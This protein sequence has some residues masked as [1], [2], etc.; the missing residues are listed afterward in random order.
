[1]L[2]Y[3][4]KQVSEELI[5]NRLNFE[6][7]WWSTGAIDPDYSGMSARLYLTLFLK[8]LEQKEVHRSIVMMGPRRV[9]KTVL[10][11]HAVSHLISKG[12]SPRKIAFINIENPI[13]LNMSLDQL[14]AYAR[15]AV[16]DSEAKGWYVFF[17]EIQY[18][19]E[20]EIHMKVL[21]D[22]YRKTKFIASGS[23]AAALRMKSRESGA[24][25]FSDFMLPPLTFHEYIHMKQLAHLVFPTKIEWAGS[26]VPFFDSINIR[27]LN[28]QFVEY[29]NFGGYPEVIFSE[30]IR[31]NPGRYIRSDILD[32]V[33]LR[34][35]PSLYGIENVQELNRLFATLAYNSGG[36]LSYQTLSS[37]SGLNK[38]TLVNYLGYLEAAFLIK[39]VHR[40][41][42]NAKTFKRSD[43]FKIYLTNP[44]LR[45]ALFAPLEATDDGMGSMVESAIFSQWLHRGWKVPYYARWTKGRFQ[46]E[47]DMVGLDAATY[48]A[49]WAVE[50]KWSNQYVGSP[51]KLVSL[52]G[53]CRNNRLKSA[54]VTTIDA[55]TSVN[56]AGLKLQ[57]I[58]SSLYA[59]TVGANT[60]LQ[61]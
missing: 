27:E 10:M 50:I 18:L 39:I 33:L 14:F 43:L 1:M 22:T 59:Y 24:G 5:L 17:D 37:A 20:W 2:K 58:P 49:R 16:A 57:F 11:H 23:A 29:I 32:K 47:V 38:K 13:F 7:P 19:P 42:D 31:S 53:F 26:L 46:G 21:S 28:R 44:S 12:V 54:V 15:K 56:H 8:L 35:L 4:L 45:S 41:D 61:K 55:F 40:V 30:T 34:D 6:N 48:K 9:G 25:R 51:G 60:L 52:A 3:P 36:E